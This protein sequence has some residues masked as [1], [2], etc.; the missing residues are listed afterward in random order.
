VRAGAAVDEQIFVSSAGNVIVDDAALAK[1]TYEVPANQSDA[2]LSNFTGP[3]LAHRPVNPRESFIN[4]GNA[5]R[6][7]GLENYFDLTDPA[8]ASTIT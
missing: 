6:V 4:Y 3:V 8:N 7:V 5:I 2:T 1:A